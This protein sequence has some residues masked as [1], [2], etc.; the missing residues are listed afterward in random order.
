MS[1]RYKHSPDVIKPTL[2]IE[3]AAKGRLLVVTGPSGAGK[4]TLVNRLLQDP[5]LGYK[6][7]VTYTDR[8]RRP[9]E[10][11][12][13]DYF[14]ISPQ[15]FQQKIDENFFAEFVPY[16]KRKGTPRA[17]FEEIMQGEK[18]IWRNDA[19]TAA[20]LNENFFPKQLQDIGQAIS[21]VTTPIYVGV[22]NLFIL[23]DRF[24]AREKEKYNPDDFSERIKEDWDV[25]QTYQNNFP[26]VIINNGT[27]DE[28]YYQALDIINNI[29]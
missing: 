2:E 16:G 3:T 5:Q 28:M 26:H 21:A 9:N 11:E 7:I 8:P 25:W 10:V 19:R 22:D 17:P 13:V 14:F 27:V 24:K 29:E 1:E 4:D 18:Y 20:T 23:K 15:E 12:G 6:R